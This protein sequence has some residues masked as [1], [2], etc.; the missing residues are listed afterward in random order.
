MVMM[1]IG[2][3]M[4]FGMN[5][6]LLGFK[7]IGET[8]AGVFSIYFKLQSFFFMPLIGINNAVISIV[9]FNYGARQPK[10]I[11]SALKWTVLTD[12]C[13]TALG[14][15]VFQLAPEL[16]L[17]IFNPSDSF[18]EMGVRALRLI[19]LHFPQA[20]LGSPLGASFQGLGNGSY[21][22]ITS[23]CRQLIALL[24]AAWLLSLSGDVNM[25]WWAFP[26]AEVVSAGVSVFLFVRIYR[27]RIQPLYRE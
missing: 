8:A 5:Q 3:V 10:R 13:I 27:K 1:G 12:M 20:A 9:A 21:S 22:T 26:I 18:L 17:S 16:L 24:P 19:G 25:V 6:I 11:T 7:G 2:S 14:C 23:L 15:A 4:N